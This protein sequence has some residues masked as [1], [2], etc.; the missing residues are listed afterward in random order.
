MCNAAGQHVCG[1]DEVL[2]SSCCVGPTDVAAWSTLGSQACPATADDPGN[3]LK[4][5]TLPAVIGDRAP[6]FGMYLLYG[7]TRPS[8]PTFR[9]CCHVLESHA[10]L[11]IRS[12]SLQD[13]TTSPGDTTLHIQVKGSSDVEHGQAEIPLSLSSA[14]LF[15][16]V[17]HCV[18]CVLV[19]GNNVPRVT[20]SRP[21]Q[22][23][24]LTGRD[25]KVPTHRRVRGDGVGVHHPGRRPSARSTHRL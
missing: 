10:T 5:L 19:Q 14:T 12:Y 13:N 18:N 17:R 8:P 15:V 4:L 25:A 21:A 9:S 23:S 22:I 16:Q 11:S 20:P 24:G 6:G 7:T 1:I 2:T 3:T